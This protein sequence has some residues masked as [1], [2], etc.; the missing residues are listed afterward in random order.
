MKYFLVL[1]LLASQH[2]F[3]SWDC[4]V[5]EVVESRASQITP[6]GK[7][8]HLFIG[9]KFSVDHDGKITGSFDTTG[10]EHKAWLADG[11]F[12]MQSVKLEDGYPVLRL[13]EI[14]TDLDG[15]YFSMYFGSLGLLA[16][17]TCT[18]RPGT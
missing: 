9:Q 12:K 13:L 17:G 11:D 14:D 10:Y 3:A 18:T 5:S 4:T 2:S 6:L 1:F 8:A 16:S 7:S 15:S